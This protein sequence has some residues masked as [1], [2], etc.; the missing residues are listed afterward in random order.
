[1]RLDDTGGHIL[2]VEDDG[3]VRRLIGDQLVRLGYSVTRVGSAGECLRTMRSAAPRLDLVLLDR[4]L[5]DGEGDEILG[6]MQSEAEFPLVP[7]IIISAD[8]S[9]QAVATLL[10]AGA[11][12][13]LVKPFE[14][15]VLGARVAAAIREARQK[16][17]L[18]KTQQQLARIK[19]ELQ[20]IFDA[21]GEAIL[22]IDRELTVRR[23]NRAGMGLTGK[24]AFDQILGR[25]CHEVLYG[26]QES[27]PDCPTR[28]AFR[29]R[30][31]QVVEAQQQVRGETV[32]HRQQAYF[33]E[34]VDGGDDMVVLVIA[35][36]TEERNSQMETLRAEKLEA[37]I[38]LAGGLAH[39][40]SQPLAAV[41]GRSELLEM[42]LEKAE[43]E[44]DRDE[45]SRHIKN[46]RTN[47]R[48]LSEIVRRLQNISNYVTKPYYGD[49]QILD[50]ERS[51]NPAA[52]R[53]A[54]GGAEY[55]R[56]EEAG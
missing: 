2:L 54:E 1:M 24:V 32:Y 40:I 45:L 15:K 50:L 41:S 49:T 21:V 28:A 27:C 42:A 14:S 11:V 37:V 23:I 31:G 36:V 39:E 34:R 4:C 44:A 51:S 20:L 18:L 7:V 9:A 38:R 8:R 10:S 5:P 56:G 12:D 13:Y 48:R 17:S 19:K 22:L 16:E 55:P 46:L 6:Q 29:E 3:D 43:K 47:S 53:A 30:K 52:P 26:R 33:L 25:K 35:D